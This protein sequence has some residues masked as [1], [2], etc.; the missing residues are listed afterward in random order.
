MI[1]PELEKLGVGTTQ[2]FTGKYQK[3]GKNYRLNGMTYTDVCIADLTYNEKYI[4]D[5]VWIGRIPLFVVK[6]MKKGDKVFVRS[7]IKCYGDNRN[8]TSLHGGSIKKL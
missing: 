1:R 7:T 4:T 5:H 8:E 3:H 2:E 6:E